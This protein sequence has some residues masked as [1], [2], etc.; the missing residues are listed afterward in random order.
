MRVKEKQAIAKPFEHF[1][2]VD[3]HIKVLSSYFGLDFVH[4]NVCSSIAI[5]VTLGN[6]KSEIP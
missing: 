6:V 2:F 3:G 5:E 4:L 1:A